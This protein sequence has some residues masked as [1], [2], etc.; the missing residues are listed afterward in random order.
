MYIYVSHREQTLFTLC[1]AKGRAY[2][3]FSKNSFFLK[4]AG[5]PLYK[6]SK[7]YVHSCAANIRFFKE[8]GKIFCI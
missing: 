4:L 3:H 7:N 6:S 1:A 2:F 8:R 5:S